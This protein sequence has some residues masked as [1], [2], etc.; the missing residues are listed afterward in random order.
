MARL[1]GLKWGREL[2][3]QTLPDKADPKWQLTARRTRKA[4]RPDTARFWPFSDKQ[5]AAP[6]NRLS[7]CGRARLF[8]DGSSGFFLAC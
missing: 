5:K 3:R 6:K 1:Q 8:R 4:D 7:I 2:T